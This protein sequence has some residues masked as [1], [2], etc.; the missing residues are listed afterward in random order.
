MKC[1]EPLERTG[2]LRQ[3]TER[4]W[5]TLDILRRNPEL[6]GGQGARTRTVANILD[7]R[8]VRVDRT[9][10]TLRRMERRGWVV[11]SHSSGVLRWGIHHTAPDWRD[12]LT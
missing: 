1:S 11:S 8:G 4:Q 10:D 12:W 6:D 7:G 3:C 2:G 9:L 5:R